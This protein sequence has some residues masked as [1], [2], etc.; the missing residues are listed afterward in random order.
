MRRTPAM[1]VHD[2][3][4]P[5]RPCITVIQRLG[6]RT[7]EPKRYGAAF[8][9]TSRYLVVSPFSRALHIDLQ[10]ATHFREVFQ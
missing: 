8:G 3:G 6:G 5:T 4:S 9:G 10:N 7:D 1:A 2:R